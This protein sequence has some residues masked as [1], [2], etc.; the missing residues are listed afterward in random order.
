[1]AEY[2]KGDISESRV[3]FKENCYKYGCGG[4]LGYGRFTVRNFLLFKTSLS[5][6]IKISFIIY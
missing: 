6:S 3:E 5:F 4:L 2:K 1:M